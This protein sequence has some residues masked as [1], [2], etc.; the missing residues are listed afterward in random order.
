MLLQLHIT[1]HRVEALLLCA[2]M[3]VYE[4][5]MMR[6]FRNII[7]PVILTNSAI[8]HANHIHYTL[9]VVIV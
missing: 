6:L 7:F 9:G 3:S 1:T 5:F 8:I 2:I 4:L